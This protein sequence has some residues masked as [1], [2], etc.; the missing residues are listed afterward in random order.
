MKAKQTQ[1]HDR[2][3]EGHVVISRSVLLARPVTRAAARP[4]ISVEWKSKQLLVQIEPS[5]VIG[6]AYTDAWGCCKKSITDRVAKVG[7]Q[8][9]CTAAS[10]SVSGRQSLE[11][12]IALEHKRKNT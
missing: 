1:T 4:G 8:E 10:M 7:H 3:E 5:N 12:T 9:Q 2:R 11:Q 6:E